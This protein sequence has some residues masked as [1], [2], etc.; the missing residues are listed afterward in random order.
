MEEASNHLQEAIKSHEVG[1]HKKALE[2]VI[3]TQSAVVL[4]SKYHQE[5]SKQTEIPDSSKST[6]PTS[7]S[8]TT[9]SSVR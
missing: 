9:T 6:A 2:S 1:D 3:R 5:S 7:A 8:S 4:A